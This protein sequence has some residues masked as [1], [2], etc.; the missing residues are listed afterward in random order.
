MYEEKFLS[1]S[2]RGK[3]TKGKGQRGKLYSNKASRYITDSVRSKG[4]YP[5]LMFNDDLSLIL[6]TQKN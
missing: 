2:A 1:D 5:L 4:I 6:L 3:M